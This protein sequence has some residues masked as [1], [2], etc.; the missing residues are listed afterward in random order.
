M[1]CIVSKAKSCRLLDFVHFLGGQ[2]CIDNVDI[3]QN[4]VSHTNNNR[5]AIIPRLNFT[6]DGRITGIMAKVR[7]RSI[8]DRDGYPYFQVWRPLSDSSMRFIKIDE[9]QLQESQV[10]NCTCETDSETYCIAYISL[11]GC[12]KILEFQTGDVVGYYHPRKSLYQVRTTQDFEYNLYRFNGSFA[13]INLSTV[14][15]SWISKDQRPLIQ[16]EIGNLY[17]CVYFP[18]VDMNCIVIYTYHLEQYKQC[19]ACSPSNVIGYRMAKLVSH[20]ILHVSRLISQSYT[21]ALWLLLCKQQLNT[22]V[23]FPVVNN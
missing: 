21:M 22:Q 14:N 18:V 13:M 5:L 11:N 19:K 1:A 2:T 4:G 15:Q 23:P 20:E 12:G 7:K 17:M 6:C 9:V 16:F 8:N 10:F 3:I